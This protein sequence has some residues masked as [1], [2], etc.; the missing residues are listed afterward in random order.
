MT[1]GLGDDRRPIPVPATV[2][3]D[4]DR[5]SL[6]VDTASFEVGSEHAGNVATGRPLEQFNFRADVTFVQSEKRY[7]HD[8]LGPPEDVELYPYP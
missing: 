5:L 6:V 7:L 2:G 4:G 3:L 1:S 8:D